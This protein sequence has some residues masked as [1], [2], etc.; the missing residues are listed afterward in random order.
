[1]SAN[2]NKKEKNEKNLIHENENKKE[3]QKIE[4]N[5]EKE[6]DNN[7][8]ILL[9]KLSLPFNKKKINKTNNKSMNKN[10]LNLRDNKVYKT[11]RSNY[12]NIISKNN[13]TYIH[14]INNT[15]NQNEKI[16][17]K[18]INEEL[19]C[20]LETYEKE[21]TK[22]KNIILELNTE[23]I[24][25]DK[26]LEESEKIIFKLKENYLNLSN[27][28]EKKELEYQKDM[29]NKNEDDISQD[30]LKNNDIIEQY[31]NEINELKMNFN[32]IK[33]EYDKQLKQLKGISLS[34][35][36]LK[37]KNSNFIEMLK[38]RE[39]IIEQNENTIK[40]LKKEINNKD[41]Q[42]KLLMKYKK[43]DITEQINNE[44]N[45]NNSM[46]DK[47]NY[48]VNIFPVN[49]QFNIDILENKILNNNQIGFKLQDALKDILFIPSNANMSLTKEYLID[50]NFKTEL[51]KLE[52]F[53]NY[54]RELN[55]VEFLDN[56]SDVINNFSLK[57]AM[58]KVYMLKSNYERIIFD[59]MKYIKENDIL[60]KKIKELYLYINK[61][62]EDLYGANNNFKLKLNFLITMYEIKINQI[63]NSK[64]IYNQNINYDNTL[65]NNNN[66]N[67]NIKY[68]YIYEHINSIWIEPINNYSNENSD[69]N[70][71][72]ILSFRVKEPVNKKINK[73]KINNKASKKEY[74]HQKKK[75]DDKLKKEIERLKNQIAILIK[76]MNENQKE[77]SLIKNDKKSIEEFK[78]N[79]QNKIN[80]F[81]SQIP[82]NNYTK[83]KNNILNISNFD[84]NNINT[85]KNIFSFFESLIEEFNDI[86]NFNNRENSLNKNNIITFDYE[87]FNKNIFSVSEYMKYLL[88][89]EFT[90]INEIINVFYF[91]INNSKQNLDKIKINKDTSLTNS[92]L[93]KNINS[94]NIIDEEIIILKNEKIINESLIEIIKNYLVVCEKIKKYSNDINYKDYLNKIFNIFIEG[95]YYRIDD[96]P[97]KDIFIRKLIYKLLKRILFH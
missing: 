25:K 41:D 82:K 18:N 29:Y 71:S 5:E 47:D 61:I 36:E 22:L 15:Y 4:N 20:N 13:L 69:N 21:N 28:Y 76:D 46:L 70:D 44:P 95:L 78:I 54:I 39:R 89:Y 23:L 86:N 40:D 37:Q 81:Y 58:D 83:I 6:I 11:H 63:K 43:E 60:K 73:F 3:E 45:K 90:N 97:D 10:N 62:K 34:N 35:Q 66:I 80:T 56:F 31:K 27:Q 9:K 96:L 92:S 19:L 79:I 33:N 53:S 30:N 57:D 38:D 75:V 17:L 55:Y 51:I 48:K 87:E 7:K 8:E 1:M 68:N 67:Y 64:P 49:E 93:D 84:K 12:N 26:Y 24:E 65:R 14:D 85:I 94:N 2:S 88:I 42:L 74:N 59:T 91:M 77:L 50:M 32:N 72:D 16:N 52:C